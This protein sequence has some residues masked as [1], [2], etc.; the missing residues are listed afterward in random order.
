MSI[1]EAGILSGMEKAA[2]TAQ[3]RMQDAEKLIRGGGSDRGAIYMNII[4]NRNAPKATRMK[5]F[6]GFM[7]VLSSKDAQRLHPAERE[8]IVKGLAE[9]VADIPEAR[10]RIGRVGGAH[11]PSGYRAGSTVAGSVSREVS[12]AVRAM[13]KMKRRALG[14]AGLAALG[15]I[16]Y[17]A[18]RNRQ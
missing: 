17:A 9:A 15:G 11:L 2:N 18:Y 1:R 12:D 14:A 13:S 10:L 8:V 7:K 5:L 16:G 4:A 3:Y 6:D